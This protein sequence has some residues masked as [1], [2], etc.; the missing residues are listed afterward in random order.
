MCMCLA[1]AVE[2]S[3]T[4]GDHHVAER[5]AEAAKTGEFFPLRPSEIGGL[6]ASGLFWACAIDCAM[7]HGLLHLFTGKPAE[8]EI[9]QIRGELLLV[10][11]AGMLF[12]EAADF[13]L[14]DQCRQYMG[15]AGIDEGNARGKGTLKNA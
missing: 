15:I 2:Q 12:I 14:I 8:S 13:A 10:H 11:K 1:Q 4:A 5:I 3:K 6:K 9:L 7:A